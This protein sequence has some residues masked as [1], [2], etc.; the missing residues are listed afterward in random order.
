MSKRI[1]ELDALRGLCILGMV[2][3][4]LIYDLTE[5][6]GLLHWE[7]PPF[8][9][10][11]MD[12][13]GI[14][15]LMLSGICVTLGS[16]PVRRG[17]TVV[18]CGLLCSAVTAAMYV[19]KLASSSVIIYFG[20]L[21]CLGLCMLLWPT[22]SRLSSRKLTALGILLI[23]MGR[24]LAG[25]TAGDTLWL[26]PFGIRPRQFSS[27]DYF[28]LLPNLGWFLFGSV[29]GRSLY[30]DKVT[31]FPKIHPERP[32]IRFLRQC[33]TLSLPIYLLHQP[34]ICA[35]LSVITTTL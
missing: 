5:L 11:I 33:G 6:Y 1:W 8:F 19:M 18:L 27:A 4:H 21:H 34:V 13:G 7:Y 32:A 12:W 17:C 3:V 14:A 35:V 15:F 2:A 26:L 25:I 31:R 28:P 9:L 29:L 22:L 23:L 10:L 24:C 16:H 30:A 20:I